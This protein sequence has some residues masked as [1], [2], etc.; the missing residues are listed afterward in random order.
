MLFLPSEALLCRCSPALGWCAGVVGSGVDI[1]ALPVLGDHSEHRDRVVVANVQ[2]EVC[3]DATSTCTH[4]CRG[5][6]I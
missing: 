2:S 4:A 3:P 6:S 1:R 5:V